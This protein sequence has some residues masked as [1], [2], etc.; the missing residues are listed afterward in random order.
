M[1]N[2]HFAVLQVFQ[3]FSYNLLD[4]SPDYIYAAHG[5]DHIHK[6]NLALAL[7]GAPSL[8]LDLDTTPARKYARNIGAADHAI[9][10]HHAVAKG[11]AGWLLPNATDARFR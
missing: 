10:Y 6:S 5:A 11:C 3:C 7:L 9:A 8:N 2:R 1:S 4:A